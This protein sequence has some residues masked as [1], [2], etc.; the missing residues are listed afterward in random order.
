MGSI[1]L[2]ILA[3]LFAGQLRVRLLSWFLRL[4]HIERR[5]YEQLGSWVFVFIFS[6]GRRVCLA[7]PGCVSH[8][9]ETKDK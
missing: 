3:G 2:I 6:S 5:N 7:A 1:V 4:T 8:A 9:I